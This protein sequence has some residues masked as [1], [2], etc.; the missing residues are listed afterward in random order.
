[1]ATPRIL[2]KIAAYRDPE[3]PKTIASALATARNP[4]KV[5]F[6]VVNQHDGGADG[7]SIAKWESDPRFQVMNVSYTQTSGLG[8]ARY[9]CD[10]M[11]SREE[12]TLQIDSHMRFDQDWDSTLV[13]EWESR[14]DPRAILT[15]YPKG[16]GYTDGV[17]VIEADRGPIALFV[18][19]VNEQGES[20]LGG[21]PFKTP[22]RRVLLVAG[23]FQFAPGTA[24]REV[25]N[26]RRVQYGDELV[27]SLR[28]YTHGY[29][30][31]SPHV[32]PLAHF[33]RRGERSP[34]LPGQDSE[35]AD[36]TRI[37]DT[38]RMLSVRANL[39]V[40][41]GAT[42]QLGTVRSRDAFHRNL[43]SYLRTPWPPSWPALGPLG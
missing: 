4:A 39:E 16:Y 10:T 3:L 6:A 36:L 33:Y 20:A 8:W 19:S 15:G 1:M 17:E 5:R 22:E 35:D 30:V 2:I 7:G 27:Q 13:A 26:D 14:E 32:F 41:F 28:L 23:G 11:W 24:S 42:A 40:L 31:Y 25:P 9:T 37:K 21:A 34:A 12:F 18:S 38:L 43:K 29:N